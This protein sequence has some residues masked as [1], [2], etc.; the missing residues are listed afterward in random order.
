MV[1]DA[2]VFYNPNKPDRNW[3]RMQSRIEYLESERSKSLDEI[4]QVYD[5]VLE[6]NEEL[7]QLKLSIN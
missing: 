7:N 6:I 2:L 1:P 5:Y 4:D 3:E